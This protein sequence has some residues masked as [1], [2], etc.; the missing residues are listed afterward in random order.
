LRI[1]LD[2]LCVVERKQF[3]KEINDVR[4]NNPFKELL[5]YSFDE[6]FNLPTLESHI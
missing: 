4:L 6:R 5:D 3:K 1:D 2:E